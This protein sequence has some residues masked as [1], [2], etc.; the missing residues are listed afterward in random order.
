MS[1]CW[2]LHGAAVL[3][4]PVVKEDIATLDRIVRE[5][6]VA[7]WWSV[8]DDYDDMLAIVLDGQVIGAIQYDEETD[9]EFRHASIDIFLTTGRHGQG[10]GTDAVRTLARWL[11]HERGHHRLTIDPAVANTAA[12][13]SYRKVGFKPVGIMRAY[14]RDYR[15]G[16]WADGLLMDL[17]ADELT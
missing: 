7:A 3:L 8:P 6:E 11:I 15:T 9:P 4:R 1:S 12:V 16:G 14:G 13:N 2:E 10:L 5:P 17:L